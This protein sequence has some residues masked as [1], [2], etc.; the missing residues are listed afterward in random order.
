MASW[1]IKTVAFNKFYRH[2]M[3]IAHRTRS[4]QA[5]ASALATPNLYDFKWSG[6]DAARQMQSGTLTAMDMRSAQRTLQMRGLSFVKVKKKRSALS[7]RRIKEAD[8]VMLVRQLAT[9]IEA[10]IPAIEAFRLLGSSTNSRQL[11]AMLKDIEQSLNDG[12]TISEAFARHPKYFD[13][14]FV[15]LI[16]SGEAGGIL[17]AVLLKLASYREKSLALKKKIR[18]AMVYPASVITIAA[19]VTSILLIFVI[20]TFSTL[21]SNFGATLPTLTLMVVNLS[22]WFRSH[23]YIILLGPPIFFYFVLRMH[24]KS[25]AMRAWVDRL[26]LQLPI[27]GQILLKGAIARFTRTFSILYAAGVPITDSLY[28]LA[29]TSGNIV[30]ESA[31]NKAGIAVTRGET[32]SSSLRDSG[33][34]PLMVTQMMAIGEESGAIE[35]MTAKIAEFYE[36]EVDEAVDRLTAL[37]EP[38]IISIL[39]VIIGTFLVAMYLPI[40]QLGAVVTHSG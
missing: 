27:I 28:T 38:I 7:N 30:I 23:W 3:A 10:G 13:G 16:E 32:M 40:F 12:L 33:I 39:G 21:F 8:I 5:K 9:M 6:R 22:Y 15:A 26:A 18:S 17:E 1:W 35:Q 14:L 31:I 11:R 24:K 29:K 25:P 37:M 2:P 34:F 36:G 20:P 4:T 19:I